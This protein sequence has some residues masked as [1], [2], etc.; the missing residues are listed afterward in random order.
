MSTVSTAGCVIS[1]WRSSRSAACD[2]ASS[3]GSTKM[4]ESAGARAAAPSPGR[5][6]R[7]SPH[8]R[9]ALAQLAQHVRRTASPGRCRGR[10]RFGRR[11]R[12]RGRCPGRAARSRRRGSSA[13]ERLQRALGARRQLGG[14]AV[15]DREALGRAQ[16]GLAGRRRGRRVAGAALRGLARAR[17]APRSAA[18]VRAPEHECAAQRRLRVGQRP[19]RRRPAPAPG[20]HR[21]TVRALAA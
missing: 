3:P 20:R 5:L 14:V 13:R 7:R 11:R 15:V 21:L 8:D 17:G 12:C 6:R 18:A 19:A 2:A 10:R 9:L 4:S 16:V 1:V